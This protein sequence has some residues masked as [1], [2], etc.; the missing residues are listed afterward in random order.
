MPLLIKREGA[1]PNLLKYSV[2]ADEEG[3]EIV[4]ERSELLKDTVAG[5]LRVHIERSGRVDNIEAA[6]RY[7]L[8]DTSMRTLI[9]QRSIPRVAIDGVVSTAKDG[10]ALKIIAEANAKAIIT[11]ERR[12]S[13]SQ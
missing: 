11:L 6:C 4:I 2:T 1:T 9:T 10:V 3:G 5:P 13:L 8:C 12:H 7:L